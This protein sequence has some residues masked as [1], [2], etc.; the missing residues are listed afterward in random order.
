M[1]RGTVGTALSLRSLDGEKRVL[2][3][4][5]HPDD[6]D[7]AL[8]TALARG[9]GVKTAYLSLTRGDGG[10][11]LIGP[12]LFEGLGV[13]RTGEL[14]AARELDGGEQYFTRAFDFGFSKSADES[15]SQWPR[16]ALL[17]D[18][19][20]VV[21]SFRPHV[22]VSVFSGTPADGHGQHQAAGIMARE[23]FEAAG[24]PS[25][26]PELAE[27]GVE[28]WQV[29]KLFRRPRGTEPTHE[30]ETGR[31][32]PLLGRSHFQ[33][34]ME[35][36]S[37]HR[38]QDMGMGQ[39]VG[40]RVTEL[41]LV[42]AAP[43]L[44]EGEATFFAGVDTT[45]AA[46]ARVLGDDDRQRVLSLVEAYRSAL[47]DAESAMDPADPAAS[48]K[49][50]AAG[51][52]QLRRAADLASRAAPGSELAR[53]L[54]GRDAQVSRTLLNAAGITLRVRSDDDLVVPGESTEVILELWNGGPHRI[55]P[56]V[57][58]LVLPDGWSAEEMALDEGEDALS[59]FFG[60]GS[61]GSQLAADGSLAPGSVARWRYRVQA[62]ADARYSRLY[63]RRVARDGAMYR[64]PVD[65]EHWALPKDPP[66]MH[67]EVEMALVID[68]VAT[69]LSLEAPARFVGVDKALGEFEKPLLVVPAVSVAMETG[70]LV[71]PVG[72]GTEREVRVRLTSFAEAP[73]TGTLE[74]RAPEG[75]I[76]S[77]P[78]DFQLAGSGAEQTVAFNVRLA[79]A[80]EGQ[81]TLQALATVDGPAGEVTLTEQVRLVDYPHI[82][83]TAM[84]DNATTEVSLFSVAADEVAV[85]YLMG[86]GDDGLLA[87]QQ[88]GVNARELTFAEI[89]NGVPDDLDVLVLGIRIYETQPQAAALNDRILDFAHGGGTVIVQYNKYEYPGG[90]FAPYRVSMSRPHDRVT[91]ETSPVAFLEPGSP[92]IRGPNTLT[93]ADFEGWV[94]ER[95][96]YF[97]RDWEPPFQPVLAFT[98]PGEEPQEGSL[99][100]A[101]YG[102]GLYVYT[103]ISFFRQFPAG[104]A[105]AYRLFANLVSLQAEDFLGR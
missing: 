31:W 95:G 4:A 20:Y 75:W 78:V 100:V 3:I 52:A 102:D 16:E 68:G 40:P 47:R 64:W 55:S 49:A 104:V 69:P 74:L 73:V 86:S 10:Q 24:D 33:L 79:G 19:T 84:F 29:S 80:A 38:S 90:R 54:A 60:R 7:T 34:A 39:P 105:G 22:I 27:F 70:T 99:L 28:P 35:S 6:E 82:E 32:D 56:A 21:R 8:L 71:W 5:A 93:E 12:E 51:L 48:V 18:V 53:V 85:G 44:V 96:L 46:G 23:V 61:S 50:L 37:Q 41:V 67:G 91:D 65:G 76:V 2:M 25:R 103:G 43:G 97:L 92:V 72:S 83:R 30:V 101:P 36:R 1:D 42:D 26:F 59:R 66:V 89:A 58:G 9:M 63:F 62:P 98:D 88:M 15:L 14:L 45:L 57:P 13:I 77:G 94:Q 87:L 17:R 81:H 11:N